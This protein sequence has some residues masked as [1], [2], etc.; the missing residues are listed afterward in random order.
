MTRGGGRYGNGANYAQH[1]VNINS[2]QYPN[3]FEVPETRQYGSDLRLP[4][5]SAINELLLQDSR[6]PTS[7]RDAAGRVPGNQDSYRMRVHSQALENM[8]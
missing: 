5:I 8:C 1:G 7:S 4:P 3:R 2:S 6:R